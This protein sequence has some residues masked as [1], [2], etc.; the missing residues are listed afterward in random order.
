M[1][2]VS[3][4]MSPA[5][6]AKLKANK[7]NEANATANEVHATLR[8]LFKSSSSYVV[9][10]SAPSLVCVLAANCTRLHEKEG[11]I[12]PVVL[13]DG[14]SICFAPFMPAATDNQQ[15]PAYQCRARCG[16]A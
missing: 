16:P 13:I 2:M 11:N 7:E 5:H 1:V 12:N 8:F 6:A 9:A 10:L 4:V 3:P 15:G 14:S